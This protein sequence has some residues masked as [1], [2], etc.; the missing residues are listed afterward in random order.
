MP[1]HAELSEQPGLHGLLAGEEPP[2]DELMNAVDAFSRTQGVANS[3]VE[4]EIDAQVRARAQDP[5]EGR[6]WFET[7][8][9]WFRGEDHVPVGSERCSLELATYWLTLPAVDGAAASVTSTTSN[10]EETA[11][12][13]K[14]AG[15]GGGP[16]FTIRVMESSRFESGDGRDESL[17]MS[18]PAIFE[19]VE[20]RRRGVVLTTYPRLVS[21]DHRT[22]EWERRVI[23]PPSPSALG[24]VEL[25]KRYRS[26]A[27]SGLT[28]ATLT[29]AAGTTWQ[30]G[31]EI[32]L[33]QLGLNVGVSSTSTYESEVEYEYELPGGHDYTARRFAG[34]PVILWTTESAVQ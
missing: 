29:F 10:A 9:R 7:V 33:A 11:A 12:T 17:V 24:E 34:L 1:I 6:G 21:V 31:A 8:K 25:T 30:L 3:P 14:I 22:M 2:E 5:S 16:T 28:T 23:D 13:V 32:E 4:D 19:R 26:A 18:C 15:I 27:S 20:V